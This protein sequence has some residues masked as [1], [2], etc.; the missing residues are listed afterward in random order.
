MSQSLIQKQE[1]SWG[2]EVDDRLGHHY[3]LAPPGFEEN[4]LCENPQ[5]TD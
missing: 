5:A 2:L 1:N 4:A 3:A